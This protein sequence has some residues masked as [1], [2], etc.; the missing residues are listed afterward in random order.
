MVDINKVDEWTLARRRHQLV[1]ELGEIDEVINKHRAEKRYVVKKNDI[2]WTERHQ[3]GMISQ[4]RRT[5]QIMSPKLGFDIHNV[6]VFLSERPPG[7]KLG[8]YHKHGEAIK[9]YLSG[10]GIEVIGDEEYEVEAGDFCFIPADIWH[11]TQNPG[12]EP[13]RFI[14]ITMESMVV[15]SPFILRQ[16]VKEK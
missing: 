2:K 9:Y 6:T 1:Q 7:E 4:G 16:D 5:A 8:A 12:T 15:K 10:K 3:M 11:G 14:A 13:L